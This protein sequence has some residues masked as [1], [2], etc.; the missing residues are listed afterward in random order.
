MLADP[1]YRWLHVFFGVMWIGMLYFFNF[2]NIPTQAKLEAATKKAVNPEL[3]P[4]ALWFFR[5]GALWTWVTGFLLLDTAIYHGGQMFSMEG[6]WGLA[7]FAMLGLTFL[8]F[9]IYDQILTRLGSNKVIG[10]VGFILIGAIAYAMTDWAHMSYRSMNIHIGAMLGTIM[11]YNVWFRIWPGQRKVISAIKAGTPPD[12]AIVA[13][14]GGRSRHNVYLSVPLLWTMINAHTTAYSGG[15]AGIPS[16][17]PWIALLVIT[18][19]GW[20]LVW[21]FYKR[22]LKVS[23]DV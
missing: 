19:I 13:K 6:S 16:N 12:A 20:H 3:L 21:Q 23:T 11:A 4:R 7:A 10:T 5:I 2:V 1:I 22:S 18:L 17:M 8:G 14:V 15:N 9:V